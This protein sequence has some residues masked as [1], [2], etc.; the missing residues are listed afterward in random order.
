MKCECGSSKFDEGRGEH[1]L[2]GLESVRLAGVPVLVCAACGRVARTKLEGLREL[3]KIV[4]NAL[5]RKRGRLAPDEFRWLRKRLGLKGTELARLMGVGPATIS[6]W[7]TAAAP[8]SSFGDRLL[9]AIAAQKGAAP[10]FDVDDLAAIDDKDD[11][12]LELTFEPTAAGWFPR[13]E[14]GRATA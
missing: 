9:R 12:P 6:R 8:I 1:R 14:A 11:A 7:E 10:L 5:V 4:L 3:E 2:L 13:R